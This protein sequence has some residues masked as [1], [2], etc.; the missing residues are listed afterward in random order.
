MG[1]IF[2]TLLKVGAA[3]AIAYSIFVPS[4]QYWKRADLSQVRA[5]KWS[6]EPTK[7]TEIKTPKKRHAVLIKGYDYFFTEQLA[8]QS[9]EWGTREIINAYKSLKKA[10]YTDDD[11]D[12]F[13]SRK[14][15]LEG[16]DI[17]DYKA[18]KGK[19]G[20][21]FCDLFSDLSKKV[22][23]ED[24]LLVLFIG[25]GGEGGSLALE[26]RTGISS[27]TFESLLSKVKPL[28][29]LVLVNSCFS[30]DIAHKIG[31]NNNISISITNK[32]KIG[33]A[34]SQFS[35]LFFSAIAGNKKA[36]YD[37]NGKISIE[38]AFDYA[39]A[40]DKFCKPEKNLAGYI[41][42][43]YTVGLKQTPQLVYQNVDPAK[44]Y[45]AD[46]KSDTE[47]RSDTE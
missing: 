1:K 32:D 42:K 11:I 22:S 41:K 30:G 13:S 17:V 29:S 43:L 4:Y 6:K 24:S 9:G 40:N 45:I 27:D 21:D 38:E 44:V 2:D 7:I 18:S 15:E 14:I 35:E 39:A 34:E 25:H 47:Q 28:Y 8:G 31:K 5:Q 20:S 33:T 36:D 23:K 19:V 10:G 16:K 37:K 3:L 26:Q 46:T 12:V